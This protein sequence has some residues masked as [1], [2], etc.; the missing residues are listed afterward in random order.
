MQKILVVLALVVFGAVPAAV[1]QKYFT[2][3]AKIQFNSDTPMEKIEAKN[4]T[5]TAVLDAATGNVEFA[6][7]IK[8]FQFAK[9]LMQEHFN[10]NYMESDKFPKAIFKGNVSNMSEVNVSKDGTYNAKVKGKLTMHGVTKDVEMPGSVKVSGGK[11][12]VA[13]TFNIACADYNI[14]IPSVVKDNIAKEIKVV[15]NAALQP[16]K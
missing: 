2:R 7:L 12:E 10:E 1:A 8:G 4:K 13:S 3:D 16:M 6:V 11:L 9:A 5:A 15:V 14:S